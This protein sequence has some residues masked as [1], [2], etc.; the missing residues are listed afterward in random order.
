MSS[1]ATWPCAAIADADLSARTTMRVG[2]AAEWLLEPADPDELRAAWCAAREQGYLPR[3]LGG[4]A[5]LL[6]EGGVLPGVVIA[7]ERMRRLFRPGAEGEDEALPTA[8]TAPLD[9]ERDPR[10]IAWC[11]ATLPSLVNA[12]KE[13]GWSGLEG[14]AGVPGQLGG[15]IAMNAGGW[16]GDLWDVVESVRLLEPH[17]EL[18]DL[19]R[20]QCSPA[21]RDGGLGERIALG[22]VL[23]LEVDSKP[24]VKERTR[25]Y[26]R[27]KNAVQ[28]VS[29]K[30]SGCI[31]KNPD[32]ELS[33]GR[34]AGQLVDECGGKGASRGDAIVSPL[35]GN[36]IVNRGAATAADVLTLIEDLRDLVAQRTGIRLETEVR[37]WRAGS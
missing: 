24:A 2:G 9:R 23:R 15:G 31:F 20:E 22:A 12:A 17:G 19:A 6:I 33:D 30:S 37:I 11:G 5:N 14:L 26:L 7:T 28:P 32:P 18:V 21:Y 1:S 25:D 10:L 29:E 36:F 3:L 8:R 27:Q 34:S 13:L 16:A 35:H 4:G